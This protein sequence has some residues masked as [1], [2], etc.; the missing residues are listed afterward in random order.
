M[1]FIQDGW[2]QVFKQNSKSG[3]LAG[4]IMLASALGLQAQE[5]DWAA[6]IKSLGNCEGCVVD[7]Q[8]F[9]DRRLSAI[10]FASAQLDNIAFENAAMSIA[11]FDGAILTGVSFDGANLGGTSFVGTRFEDVTFVGAN[12]NGAVFEDAIFERTDL[13]PALLCNTQISGDVMDNSDCE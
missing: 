7:G 13:G 4:V 5:I 1:P 8:D 2:W 6:N 10:N 11:I 9:S 12:L 3:G